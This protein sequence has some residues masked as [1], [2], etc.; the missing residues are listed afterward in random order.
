MAFGFE[1]IAFQCIAGGLYGRQLCLE[2]I[3]INFNIG[4]AFGHIPAVQSTDQIHI[5]AV[6][7]QGEGQVGPAVISI[8]QRCFAAGYIL[9]DRNGIHFR[10]GN[11]SAVCIE[12]DGGTG[13]QGRAEVDA[14]DGPVVF[15]VGQLQSIVATV[16]RC[17][18]AGKAVGNLFQS[19]ISVFIAFQAGSNEQT[20]VTGSLEVY[21]FQEV[22]GGL[23]GFNRNKVIHVYHAGSAFLGGLC[24]VKV[25]EQVD[26]IGILR[27]GHGQLCPLS[28]S[29]LNGCF[30]TVSKFEN[31]LVVCA[32][33]KD[34]TKCHKAQLCACRQFLTEA[35]PE[36]GIPA[37]SM[38]Q[39]Q[40]VIAAVCQCGNLGIV[41]NSCNG[42]RL[43]GRTFAVKA[44]GVADFLEI[45]AYQEVT[46]SLNLGPV[47]AV[48]LEQIILCQCILAVVGE[49]EEGI[50][51]QAV[52]LA[53]GEALCKVKGQNDGA[54][55]VGH[56]NIACLLGVGIL[57]DAAVVIGKS[58]VCQSDIGR[59]V[60]IDLDGVGSA[61]LILEGQRAG[62]GDTCKF[63]CLHKVAV[64]C[65]HQT[66]GGLV[67]IVVIAADEIG[68]RCVAE[69][70]G[71]GA[72]GYF[73]V[74]AGVHILGIDAAYFDV[75]HA[76]I[77]QSR[78]IFLA[79]CLKGQCADIAVH[80]E[81]ETNGGF[82]Q[83]ADGCAVE[84]NAVN[85]SVYGGRGD[86]GGNRVGYGDIIALVCQAVRLV[87]K[88]LLCPSAQVQQFLCQKLGF[89][90]VV[91]I[92]QGLQVLADGVGLVDG[93]H[94]DQANLCLQHQVDLLG[95][96]RYCQFYRQIIDAVFIRSQIVNGV[97]IGLTCVGKRCGR[98][99]PIICGN[100]TAQ[101]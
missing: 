69:G 43:A 10:I 52:G 34:N 60:C 92:D 41:G 56:T 65:F 82:G 79:V 61:L 40:C 47:G 86:L 3:H 26:M 2:V 80:L 78:G 53:C 36:V 42:S 51:G 21:A 85:L 54:V 6:G 16:F 27:Q 9:K 76:I 83:E 88:V 20:F 62:I 96:L 25:P 91:A 71:I 55:H 33:A 23:C 8:L 49:A 90:G 4:S 101:V 1:V 28:A 45:D 37:G 18:D 77:A 39:L 38:G 99:F 13:L 97:C 57:V 58:K 68:G 17:S 84:Y 70:Q 50:L 81:V 59:Q 22:A 11:I 87:V 73:H 72:V 100:V 95:H 14:E 30:A 64:G 94:I 19:S 66:L 7:S 46:G 35:D 15:C 89:T 44:E 93:F 67:R 12:G 31:A 75:V 48:E 98:A 63:L 74:D 32:V 29:K 24:T 5:A